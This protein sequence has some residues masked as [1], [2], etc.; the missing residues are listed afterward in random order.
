M[1][2]LILASILT[3]LSTSAFAEWTYVGDAD[4]YSLTMYANLATIR[5]NGHMVKMWDLSDYKTTIGFSDG[6][7]KLS[8]KSQVEY[9]CKE[10]RSR[11]LAL[12]DTSGHMGEGDV[13]FNSSNVQNWSPVSPDS[14]GETLW[15]IACGKQ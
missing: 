4:D 9:D 14:I 15:K 12:I 3:L 7:S 1:K 8:S 13:V 10:E 11:G 2:K 5:K 6:K